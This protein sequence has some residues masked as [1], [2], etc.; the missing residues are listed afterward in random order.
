MF[1]SRLDAAWPNSRFAI[2][3]GRALV[4]F[5]FAVSGL[6]KLAKFS[7]VAAMLAKSGLPLSEGLTVLVIV[8]EIG[9]GL[10]L[11]IGWHARLAAAALV[12]FVVIATL[13]FHAFWAA[14]AAAYGNQLNHFL[15]NV[16]LL[17]ALLMV[18]CTGTVPHALPS[19]Q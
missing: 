16:A 18:A 2:A 13:M 5:L 6:L 11:V 14:D 9:A 17:G 12:P 3:A 10:S 15:K 19:G 1:N 7:Y 4:G 8:V